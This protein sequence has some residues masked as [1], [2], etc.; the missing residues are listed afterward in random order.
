MCGRQ[1]QIMVN[2]DGTANELR[3]ILRERGIN[4][5]R[6]L[7]DDMRVVLSNHEDFATEKTILEHYLKGLLRE[8]GGKQCS[9]YLFYAG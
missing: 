7:A 6:M 2:S 5:E 3:T 1:P 8:F 4:T 9:T